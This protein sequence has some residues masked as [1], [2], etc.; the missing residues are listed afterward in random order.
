MEDVIAIDA[1]GRLVVPKALRERLALRPG[2][3]LRARVREASLV[4]EPVH[5]SPRLREVDGL[6]VIDGRAA[7]W[8]DHREVRDERI[9]RPSSR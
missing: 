8:P 1:Y 4:L 3:R 5:E 7:D 2:T 6:F 9:S